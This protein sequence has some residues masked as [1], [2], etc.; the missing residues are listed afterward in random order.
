[1]KRAALVLLLLA[2]VALA[3]V[4]LLWEPDCPRGTAMRV[5]P[6]CR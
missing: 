3:A 1:M 6:A 4:P 5:V 2:G